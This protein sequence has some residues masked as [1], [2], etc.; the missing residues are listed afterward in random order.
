M[1]N[2]DIQEVTKSKKR[3]PSRARA[4]DEGVEVVTANRV[5][6]DQYCGNCQHFDYVEN[7]TDMQPYCTLYE[8]QMDDMKACEWWEQQG[9]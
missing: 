6:P 7:G 2:S 5:E 4:S 9:A 3:G 8:E 1:S